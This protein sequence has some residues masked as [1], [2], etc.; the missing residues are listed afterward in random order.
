[1]DNGNSPNNNFSSF[2]SSDEDFINM[3]LDALIEEAKKKKQKLKSPVKEN[4]SSSETIFGTNNLEMEKVLQDI[5]LKLSHFLRND[6]LYKEIFSEENKNIA[7][8][9]DI[10]RSYEIEQTNTASDVWKS[11]YEMEQT[12]TESDVTKVEN[13]ISFFL[14]SMIGNPL[15]LVFGEDILKD[16][17][18]FEKKFDIFKEKMISSMRF[19]DDLISFKDFDMVYFPIKH[20]GHYYLLVLNL[21]ELKFLLLDNN[22]IIE[23]KSC[24]GA[25]LYVGVDA[26]GGVPDLLITFISKHLYSIKHEKFYEVAFLVPEKLTLK[27]ATKEN[28]IDNGV[29]VMLHMD[30]Y[31]DE[32]ASSWNDT[33]LPEGEEQQKQLNKLRSKFATK[34][35]LSNLNM[36][37]HEFIKHSENFD[38]FPIEDKKRVLQFA[39][40]NWFKRYFD[41]I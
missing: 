12:N 32:K 25:D 18:S 23:T 13:I 11:P 36:M 40:N 35:L 37:K 9:E 38:A 20:F 7:E 4:S 27:W 1:M 26:Y 39:Y 31:I 2:N 34:I 14:Y 3:D 16:S 33:L 10:S 28:H 19:N 21:K 17:L 29:Y 22:K 41:Y 6:K 5:D 24:G 30:S 8:T 15:D